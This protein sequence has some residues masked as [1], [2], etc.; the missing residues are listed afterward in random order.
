MALRT[1]KSFLLLVSLLQPLV[2]ADEP[3]AYDVLVEH[4][5]PAGLLPPSVKD[6][7]V[8]GNGDF[9]VELSAPCY[10]NVNN[11]QTPVYYADTL[12][13]QLSAGKLS[14]LKGI[15]AKPFLFWLQVKTIYVDLP[16]T[17]IIHFSVGFASQTIPISAFS[18]SPTCTDGEIL[19]FS[20]IYSGLQHAWAW[21]KQN[22]T[23]EPHDEEG[24][25]SL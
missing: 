4:N 23:V 19:N 24:A 16:S 12:T 17:G 5:L 11:G 18:H 2:K 7:K 22:G 6:Y 21:L 25:V 8:G 1:L 14:N 13:G 3:S 9:Q 10:A 15:S 20:D